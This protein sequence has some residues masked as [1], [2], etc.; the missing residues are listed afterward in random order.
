MLRSSSGRLVLSATDLTNHLGC[1]HLTH[2][3]RR[4]ALGLRDEAAARGR[5]ARGTRARARAG[6]RGRAAR[7]FRRSRGRVVRRPDRARGMDGR[8]ARARRRRHAGRDARGRAA[9]LPGARSSTAAGRA[10]TD[11]LRRIEAPSGLGASRLRGARHEAR[12]ARSSRSVVH[13]LCLYN[14]L[15]A[16]V[17]GLRARATRYVV[18]GNG[19]EVTSRAAPLRARCTATPRGV[20]SVVVDGAAEP[21]LP[22]AGRALRDLPL[23]AECRPAPASPTTT[24]A[25]SPARARDQRERARR[26]AAS[27]RSPA[28]ARRAERLEPVA[29]LPPSASSCCTT[30]PT[31]Q[32]D[33]ATTQRADCAASCQPARAARLRAPARAQSPGDIFFDL[34]GDPYVGDGGIEYLWGWWTADGGY[35]CA[36]GAR[37]DAEKR[38]A[39]SE[40]IDRVVE[41]RAAHPGHARLPLRAARAV[42]SCARSRSSTRT[43]EA[44]VDDLLRDEVLVDLY[45]VVRQGLQVGEESYSLKKLERHHGFVRL[46]QRVREGGGSIVAYESWLETG[47]DDAA[48]GDPRL[49]RGGLP[50]D[51]SRCATGCS[52]TMRPEA[53]ARVRRRLRRARA[54]P[55]PRRS[56]GRRSGCPTCWR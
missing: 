37:L 43:R 18:L 42:A 15:L 33:R 1:L 52:T 28:L 20:S 4:I 25:S 40:F 24:S 45:A 10:A 29:A 9:D 51:R 53:A 11:F 49:Q 22:R 54:S 55:S 44:E 39:S 46:E 47:D 26:G 2:E 31:L 3:R 6:P 38:R 50:L 14:R 12:H 17:Q 7:S 35:D 21:D 16:A 48:R 13:Q 30:R 56:T 34:E 27:R 5:P 36:L 23:A 32:V 19:E 41:P 8:G